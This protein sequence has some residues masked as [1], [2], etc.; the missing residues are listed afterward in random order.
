MFWL[1]NLPKTKKLAIYKGL[2]CAIA[3]QIIVVKISDIQ[4]AIPKHGNHDFSEH[5]LNAVLNRSMTLAT[6][7]VLPYFASSTSITTSSEIPVIARSTAI[8]LKDSKLERIDVTH[9][10][11]YIRS[12]AKPSA[13]KSEKMNTN[14]TPGDGQFL[15]TPVEENQTHLNL[16]A[17]DNF[18]LEKYKS[19]TRAGWK[20]REILYRIAARN[21]ERRRVLG[22]T[23][24]LDEPF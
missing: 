23:P 8:D 9:S 16:T 22:H 19:S 21:K 2:F 4:I 3:L 10:K 18:G 20:Q 12:A 5:N 13:Y 7:S 6:S 14:S 11:I 15:P 1:K 17:N 24:T